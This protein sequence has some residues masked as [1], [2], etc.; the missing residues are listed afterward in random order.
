LNELLGAK[1]ICQLFNFTPVFFDLCADGFL[2]F[3][4]GVRWGTLE[5]SA[6]LSYLA[7]ERTV[8]ASRQITLPQPVVR[9]A[10]ALIG[11]SMS[12]P[13]PQA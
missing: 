6:F 10:L 11:L 1:L 8:S 12:C 5:V 4:I 9:L 3:L 2:D 13:S 7:V